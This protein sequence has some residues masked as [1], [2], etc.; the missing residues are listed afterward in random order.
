MSQANATLT[1]ITRTRLAQLADL[2]D[3]L[4]AAGVTV[5][6]PS[7]DEG[8]GRQ[9]QVRSPDGLLIKINELDQELYT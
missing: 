1:P 6:Q 7:S 3:R 8:F 4:R 2:E 9:L 5:A